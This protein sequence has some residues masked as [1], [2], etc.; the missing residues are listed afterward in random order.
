MDAGGQW[1]WRDPQSPR[2]TL[3]ALEHG[4]CG[5]ACIRSLIL[6]RNVRITLNENQD[7]VRLLYLGQMPAGKAGEALGRSWQ[8]GVDAHSALAAFE[9]KAAGEVSVL[10]VE[11]DGKALVRY[12]AGFD[13][14]GLKKDLHKVLRR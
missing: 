3:V 1:A 4:A 10:L 2:W 14:D 9:P 8:H 5:Q 13:A 6:L 7:R 12:P 11:P